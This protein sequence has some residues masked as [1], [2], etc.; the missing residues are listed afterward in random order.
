MIQRRLLRSTPCVLQVLLAAAATAMAAQAQDAPALPPLEPAAKGTWSEARGTGPTRSD[1][2]G[3]AIE[4]AVMRVNGLRVATGPALR[5]RLGLVKNQ[6]GSV[7][8]TEGT[9]EVARVV[10]QLEG[11]VD[12]V[13]VKEEKQGANGSWSVH[14]RCLVAGYDP[15]RA[16]FVVQLAGSPKQGRDLPYQELGSCLLVNVDEET[17]TQSSSGPHALAGTR[18]AECL[19]NTNRVKIGYRGAGVRL[20]GD[21]DPREAAKAGKGLVATHRI[22]I[23]WDPVV[24][25]VVTRKQSK[26]RP[27][28]RRH[29][30]LDTAYV[31]ARIAVRNLVE[32]TEI[33]VFDVPIVCPAAWFRQGD[34]ALATDQDSLRGYAQRVAAFAEGEVAKQVYFKLRPPVVL[35]KWQGDGE[36]A[37]WFVE[38]DLPRHVASEFA[39]FEFGHK[40]TVSGSGWHPVARGKL[41]DGGDTSTFELAPGGD[42]AAIENGKTLLELLQPK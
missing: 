14:V 38:V 4:G 27:T 3:Q 29:Q 30:D 5:A 17:G 24:V 1:A 6:D 26:S 34:E 11:F 12:Q 31:T 40:G 33:P 9:L 15:K 13:E 19:V 21:S 41:V 39:V 37:P 23:E 36:R 18:V 7:C 32:K 16:E 2:L 42:V 22:D 28:S 35:R 25:R 8:S 10:H 20:D